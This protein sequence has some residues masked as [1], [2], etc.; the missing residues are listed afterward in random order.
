M[1]LSELSPFLEHLAAEAEAPPIQHPAMPG[2]PVAAVALVLPGLAERVD[3]EP[4]AR[5]VPREVL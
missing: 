3:L 1:L 4:E 2:N 5:P